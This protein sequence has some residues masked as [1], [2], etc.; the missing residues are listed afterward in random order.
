MNTVQEMVFTAIC[1][2][3]VDN[4]QLPMMMGVCSPVKFNLP[5]LIA[6]YSLANEYYYCTDIS[7]KFLE[8]NHFFDEDRFVSRGSK[9]NQPLTWEHA[10]PCNLIGKY[11]V[12]NH[13]TLTEKDVERCL[14]SVNKVVILTRDEDNLLYKNLRSKMPVGWKLF[15]DSW[16]ARYEEVGIMVNQDKKVKMKNKTY[17]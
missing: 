3:V 9:R 17:R 5:N 8:D 4:P 7:H 1:R 16:L 11:F 6:H 15:E 12:E 2:W 13:E 10:I 14:E